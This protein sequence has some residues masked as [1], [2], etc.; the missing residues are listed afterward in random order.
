MHSRPSPGAHTSNIETNQRLIWIEFSF[1]RETCYSKIGRKKFP[2]ALYN[3]I[4]PSSFVDTAWDVMSELE[5]GDF[6]DVQ[7]YFNK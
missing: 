1:E 3:K 6:K 4:V 5:S 2:V 7:N